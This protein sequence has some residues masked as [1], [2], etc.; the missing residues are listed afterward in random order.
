[1]SPADTP[2][3]VALA[4][5]VGAARLLSGLVGI[6]EPD[7]LVIIGNTGDDLTV[8][9]LRVCP[10]LDTVCYTLGG[11]HHRVQG[12]GRAEETFTVAGELAARYDRPTWFQLG[13]RDL[14]THLLR[15][16][17]LTAGHTLSEATAVIARAWGV[18]GRLLPM[19][20][21]EVTTRI[22]TTDGRD[23]HFQEWW[24]RERGVPDVAEVRFDGVRRASPAPGVLEA[25]A[26]ADIVILCPSN[27]VVSL[28]PILAVRGIRDALARPKVVG[29][30]PIV[31]G[32]VVRGM[33]DRLLGVWGAE[34]S[35]AAVAGLYADVL[36]GWVLDR[37]DAGLAEGLTAAGVDVAVTDT[38]MRDA[39]T[40]TALARTALQLAA[41]GARPPTASADVPLA[42]DRA[43]QEDR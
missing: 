16:D 24:V 14:A 20:D 1:M 42:E 43:A 3:V 29:I 38:I 41:G 5:G 2:R 39:A 23:L 6:V 40:T 28:G 36:D 34:V 13:D 22:H 31:G 26:A 17:L 33:A 11:G 8:H 30:S 37:A 10:D 21:A 32:Q 25:L 35:A 19:S 15:H 12:W 18:P 4:G 27:P 9:G 7:A